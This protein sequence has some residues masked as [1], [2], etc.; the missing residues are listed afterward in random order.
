MAYTPYVLPFISVRGT[1][2]EIGKQYGAMARERIMLHAMNQ[3]NAMAR[4]KPEDPEWWRRELPKYLP[5]YEELAPYMVE[6]MQGIACGAEMDLDDILLINFRD[7]IPAVLRK[8]EPPD[9]GCTSF[10]LRG[11]ITLSGQPV[12]GQTKDTE[13]ISADL[14]V[15]LAMYQKGRPD[16]LQMPY[17]G[18][19]AV[20]G[21]ST[22]G[23]SNF[24]NSMFL[25]GYRPSRLPA[26]LF[27]RLVLESNSIQD[28]I[29][30]IEKYGGGGGGN[31]TVG[32]AS[33]RAVAI[34]RS[35]YGYVVL[36]QKDGIIV[37]ANNAE[38]WL[39]KYEQ[40]QEDEIKGS[41]NR[42][43]RLTSFF[44]AES[45]RLTV[46]LVFRGLQD[47]DNFPLSVCRHCF[48]EGSRRETAALPSL[49]GQVGQ[50]RQ[51][52]VPESE[53]WRTTAALVIEPQQ[54]LMHVIRGQPCRGFPMTYS[55]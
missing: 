29:D 43:V 33:G 40:W 22:T 55:L 3:K 32:E 51:G 50:S 11:D 19:L 42:V 27:R 48:P 17:A 20:F 8:P 16:I 45:G 10:A 52:M 54:H 13:A 26:S 6:E 4:R 21:F 25:R 31:M 30:L 28:V 15:V 41:H 23:M 35:A 44:K 1:P 24:G 7:N 36:E 39:V 49:S 38:S 46:P 14:Y 34:E 53:Q 37:H 12:L 9:D 18:E 47:H 5:I 2:F